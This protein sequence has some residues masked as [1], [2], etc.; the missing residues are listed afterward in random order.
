[1]NHQLKAQLQGGKLLASIKDQLVTAT[2]PGIALEQIDQL[3]E[4]LLTQTGGQPSFQLV[5]G[6]HWAT[7]I[8]LNQGLVHGIPK[9][10]FK[11]GD[12]ATIDVGLFFKGYH[13]DTSTSFIV[14]AA[15]NATKQ[16]LLNIGRQTLQAAINQVKPGNKIWDISHTIQTRIEAA[17]FSVARNLTGHGVGKELHQ[18]PTITCYSQGNRSSSPAIK[19]GDAL[20]VE[21]IYCQG[22]HQTVVES[23]GWTISTKDGQLSAVFEDTV[24]V[25]NQDC[26]VATQSLEKK[27]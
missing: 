24:L 26:L 16:R 20:A 25:T 21:V 18:E 6:Y 8:N 1:M 19:V 27:N 13:T 14:G 17:G 12:L 22:S 5:P 2:K 7:C 15:K 9:G 4:K 10:T 3:A 23:D 11:K